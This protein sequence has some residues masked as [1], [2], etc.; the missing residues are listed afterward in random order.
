M[1]IIKNK[2]TKPENILKEYPNAEIFDVT[3]KGEYK[4]L[5]PFYPHGGIPIP[6]SGSVTSASVE[7]IWQGLKV[8]GD[9]GVDLTLFANR[10]MKNLKR[11]STKENPC[12]GHQ[13]GL[14]SRELLE[15][16]EARKLIV[17]IDKDIFGSRDI[18]GVFLRSQRANIDDGI[19][20]AVFF[21]ILISHI[22][23]GVVTGQAGILGDPNITVVGLA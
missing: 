17:L 13:K 23:F 15:Y 19:L 21:E 8:F 1:I 5:S 10:S 3:S 16:I 20:F 6:F 9:K 22:L 2:R 4:R 14:S 11:P 7:G 18:K 12:L